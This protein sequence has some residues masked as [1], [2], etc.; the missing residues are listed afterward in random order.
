VVK[1]DE[2]RVLVIGASSGVGRQIANT[3]SAAG[4]RV[5]F[6]AR[7][8]ELVEEAAKV[9]G[10]GAVGLAC[11]VRDDDS[12]ASVVAGTVEAFGG[13]DALIYAAALSPL[14]GLDRATGDR[15][16]EALEI[17]IVGAG[18]VTA[19]A[20]PHLEASECGRVMY[21]SSVS[22][23]TSAPWPG[24]GIYAVSKAGLERMSDC[25][26]LEHPKV[27]FSNLV[28]GPIASDSQTPGSLFATWQPEATEEFLPQWS[29]KGLI[30]YDSLVVD[31]SEL[32]ETVKVI[33]TSAGSFSRV[34]L[35][36]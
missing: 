18:L 12:C 31:A 15:W 26:R 25:W 11:D 22:G 13:L 27:R 14:E 9:A 36:P 17:N 19:A 30:N 24:L 20:I 29:E 1:L 7:R 4:A 6:A 10:N 23:A 32:A 34:V 21:L 3:L 16:R 5:A 2:R 28:L 8:G 33:L 35:E